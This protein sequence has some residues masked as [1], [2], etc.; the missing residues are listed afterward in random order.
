MKLP[1]IT[2]VAVSLIFLG[3]FYASYTIYKKVAVEGGKSLNKVT[4]HLEPYDSARKKT[5]QYNS[6]Q[7]A[8]DKAKK[9]AKEDAAIARELL[10]KKMSQKRKPKQEDK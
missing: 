3:L 5:K 1:S 6:P 8:G 9:K 10:Q 7:G 4:E 2:F